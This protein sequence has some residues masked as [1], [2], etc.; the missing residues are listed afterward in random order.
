MRI[1]SRFFGALAGQNHHAADRGNGKATVGCS[2]QK[3]IG[4]EWPVTVVQPPPAE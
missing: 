1:P 3:D 2:E 4:F